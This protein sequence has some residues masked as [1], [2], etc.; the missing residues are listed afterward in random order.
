[1]L[2]DPLDERMG[3]RLRPL[4]SPGAAKNRDMAESEWVDAGFST[5][6]PHTVGGFPMA[7][8]ASAATLRAT[9]ALC[10]T[11]TSGTPAVMAARA[12]SGRT[13]RTARTGSARS[14]SG[15]VLTPATGQCSHVTA[16]CSAFACPPRAP[17][18]GAPIW[19][20]SAT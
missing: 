7:G 2:S 8:V 1:M 20:A 3:Y 6:H 4:R 15:V 17:T 11:G 10:S 13:F 12:R 14:L 19:A 16:C 9:F 5:G 18:F